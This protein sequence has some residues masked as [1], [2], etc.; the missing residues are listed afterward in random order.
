MQLF[1]TVIPKVL[2]FYITKSNTSEGRGIARGLPLFIRGHFNLD[3]SFF[4][5]SGALTESLGGSWV[6]QTRN[7]L[8]AQEKNGS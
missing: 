7:F 3:L 2:L 1:Q 4:C 8:L 6:F 5:S